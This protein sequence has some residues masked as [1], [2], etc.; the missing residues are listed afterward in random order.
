MELKIALLVLQK[1]KTTHFIYIIA[2]LTQNK[3]V[4]ATRTL[5]QVHKNVYLPLLVSMKL[6][7]DIVLATGQSLTDGVC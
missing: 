7:Y 4:I 1:T 6:F 2:T 3:N 5:Y